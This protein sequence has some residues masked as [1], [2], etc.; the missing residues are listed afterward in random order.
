MPT[1]S[2]RVGEEIY[3]KIKQ[4]ADAQGISLSDLLRSAVEQVLTESANPALSEEVTVLQKQLSE[5]DEEI[6]F[7]RG[8]LTAIRQEASDAAQRS[9]TIVL[10]LTGQLDRA[11]FQIEDL[12]KTDQ[13]SFWG[14]LFNRY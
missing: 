12:R 2:G 5:K 14:R 7:L 9:D 8:E 6:Q 4:Q 11:N 3:D 1:I 10:G 13:R